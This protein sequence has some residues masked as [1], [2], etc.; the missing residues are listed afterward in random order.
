METEQIRIIASANIVGIDSA[1]DSL[2]RNRLEIER[3][4]PSFCALGIGGAPIKQA[5]T[6][7]TVKPLPLSSPELAVSL[8]AHS[9]GRPKRSS[10]GDPDVRKR[11]RASG[12]TIPGPCPDEEYHVLGQHRTR[13]DLSDVVVFT[14]RDF[15]R[16][17]CRWGFWRLG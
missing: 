7:A 5:Q 3:A 4:K 13:N 10:I 6:D 11:T 12:L 15:E 1:S 17:S 14:N 2:L 9:R 16:V 8:P